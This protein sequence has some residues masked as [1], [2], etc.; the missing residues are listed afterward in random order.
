MS[1]SC[2]RE[3]I[4]IFWSG[5]KSNAPKLPTLAKMDRYGLVPTTTIASESAFS[6]SEKVISEECASLLLDIVEPLLTTYDWIESRRASNQPRF[7]LHNH[8]AFFIIVDT[9]KP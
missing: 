5:K 3:K 9:S 4:L 1:P 7:V 8:H 6:V 2:Q